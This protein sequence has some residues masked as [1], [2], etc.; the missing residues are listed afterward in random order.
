MRVRLDPGFTYV[1]ELVYQSVRHTCSSGFSQPT[2]KSRAGSSVFRTQPPGNYLPFNHSKILVHGVRP[3]SIICIN[4]SHN[5]VHWAS[6]IQLLHNYKG[7][8]CS[9]FASSLLT[10]FLRLCTNL[11]SQYVTRSREQHNST[12]LQLCQDGLKTMERPW[13]YLE[14]AL[15][16]FN[17]ICRQRNKLLQIMPPVFSDAGY[18]WIHSSS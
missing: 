10:P 7:H 11:D 17:Q 9:S 5:S 14:Q 18:T 8:H 15:T 3:V 4:M 1:R 13:H 6:N 16:W 12:L 2:P